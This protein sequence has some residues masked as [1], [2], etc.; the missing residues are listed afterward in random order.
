MTQY[1]VRRFALAIPLILVVITIVFLML[2]LGL[3]GDPAQ[4]MAGDRAT[5]E[6][7]EQIRKNLGLDRSIP[8]QY[9]I[10]LRDAARGDLEQCLLQY[11]RARLPFTLVERH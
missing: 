8:E 2:R 10:F 3:H 7:I 4:I 1:I 5:P 9:I 6:L 11:D